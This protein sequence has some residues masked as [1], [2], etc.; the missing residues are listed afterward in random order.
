MISS[1]IRLA[2]F[3]IQ[4]RSLNTY[5]G[6][7]W[8][9]MNPLAQMGLL[10]F[11]MTYVFKSNQPNILLWLISGLATWI[12][13]QSSIMRSCSSIVSRRALIQNNNIHHSLLVAADIL[14]EAFVLVPFFVIGV[15]VTFI[16]GAQSFNLFLIPLVLIILMTFLFGIGLTFATLTPAF[17]DLPYLMGLGLQVAFWLTPI[18]YSKSTMSGAVRTIVQLNPF[19][20]FI[21]LSQAVFLGL[22]LS[23]GL[24]TIPV[25]LSVS[26]CILGIIASA[27]LG[28]RMVIHL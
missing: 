10:Y 8:S 27:K 20:H 6:W 17:R 4:K 5:A 1:A 2:L 26:F 13:I 14:S 24:V 28:K 19:T 18:A 12:V 16:V 15:G 22:P 21:E 23:L 25:A 11:I 9:L 3:E 7:M